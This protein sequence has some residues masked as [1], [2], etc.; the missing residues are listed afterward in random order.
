MR[1]KELS[2]LLSITSIRNSGDVGC[3]MASHLHCV[4]CSKYLSS[5]E[6]LEKELLKHIYDVQ[7][8]LE[9]IRSEMALIPPLPHCA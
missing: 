8:S 4:Y 6:E 1:G 3:T 7:V 2:S 9:S 5:T